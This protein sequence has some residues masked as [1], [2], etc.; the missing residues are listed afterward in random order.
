MLL[1]ADCEICNLIVLI[2]ATVGLFF[3]VLAVTCWEC[4]KRLFG[5]PEQASQAEASDPSKKP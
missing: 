3:T 5:K 2:L 1:K 4:M